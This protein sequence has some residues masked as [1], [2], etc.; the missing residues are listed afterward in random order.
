MCRCQL[1]NMLIASIGGVNNVFNKCMMAWG[2]QKP[3]L[4]EN[5]STNSLKLI[6][7]SPFLSHFCIIPY[8]SRSVAKKP[9]LAKKSRSS[10]IEREPLLFTSMN[11][12]ACFKLKYGRCRK[13]ARS[14][15]QARSHLKS[16]AQRLRNS[17]RVSALKNYVMGN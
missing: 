7:P 12:N 15:S 3:S 5:S 4:G 8:N 9:L 2:H 6:R 10:S 1:F 16:D 11:A 17:A 14:T 13:L